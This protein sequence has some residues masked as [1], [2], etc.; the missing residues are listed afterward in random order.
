V[1]FGI[2]GKR[3]PFTKRMAGRGVGGFPLYSPASAF[4]PLELVVRFFGI[5]LEPIEGCGRCA[6]VPSSSNA[7]TVAVLRIVIVVLLGLFSM[8]T[9]LSRSFVR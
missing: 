7:S 1:T 8:N 9:V 4:L 5:R 3:L 2:H 6:V